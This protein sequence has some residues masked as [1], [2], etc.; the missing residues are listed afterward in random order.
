METI[1]TKTGGSIVVRKKFCR[2]LNYDVMISCKNQRQGERVV[3]KS[4]DFSKI[5]VMIKFPVNA[6]TSFF[7]PLHVG[8]SVKFLGYGGILSSLSRIIGGG[9][10]SQGCTLFSWKKP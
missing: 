9:G 6:E 4:S 5:I 3:K 1:A 2:T 7:S 8:T 10:L